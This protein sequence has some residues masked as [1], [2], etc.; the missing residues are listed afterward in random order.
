MF[1]KFLKAFNNK[2]I[3][4]K[5]NMP[6][7]GTKQREDY[8][9]LKHVFDLFTEK[10]LFKLINQG[11]INGLHSPLSSGKEAHV[12]TARKDDETRVIKIY[13]LQTCDFNR[14]YD[15]I[16]TDPRYSGLKSSRRDVIFAWAHREYRNLLKAREAEVRVPTP[17]TVLFNILVMEFIGDEQA[18]QKLN[19]DKPE[20]PK[21]FFEEVVE[22]MRK[23]YK[24]GLVHGDLS[25]FNILNY[26]Q[27]PVF[28]DMSQATPLDNSNAEAYLKRDIHNVCELF[29][30]W[31]VK[32]DEEEVLKKIIK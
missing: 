18:A 3:K 13:R 23:L 6:R 17:Y 16:K 28:I 20:N 30:K 2:R 10:N 32:A 26:N 4:N 27:K 19:K 1:K 31:E 22:Q 25:G 29:R 5:N 11:Y 21:K 12:F 9:T 15:C 8:K 24:A 7:M 14:M